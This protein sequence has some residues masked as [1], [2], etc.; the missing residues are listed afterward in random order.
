MCLDLRRGSRLEVEMWG[1]SRSSVNEISWAEKRTAAAK[2]LA[3]TSVWPLPLSQW[4]SGQLLPF[5]GLLSQ[6]CCNHPG[7]P[8]A[9]LDQHLVALHLPS[10]EWSLPG[11]VGTGFCSPVTCACRAS[12]PV[13]SGDP[14][15]SPGCDRSCSSALIGL[16]DKPLYCY[17]LCSMV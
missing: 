8:T 11:K 9:V 16:V 4:S 12:C 3:L 10:E 7:C 13:S 1:S 15:L 14:R 17:S 5:S 6:A 2:D